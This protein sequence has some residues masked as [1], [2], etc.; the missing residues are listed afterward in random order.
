MQWFKNVLPEFIV[1][2]SVFSL[3]EVTTNR[4]PW[5]TM[6]V[7]WTS[8]GSVEGFPLA[9]AWMD[10]SSG[11]PSEPTRHSTVLW[12]P[13]SNPPPRTAGPRFR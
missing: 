4:S 13:E 1:Q 11:L 9:C 8:Q 2:G 10:T 6:M 3:V 12:D 7:R 5:R